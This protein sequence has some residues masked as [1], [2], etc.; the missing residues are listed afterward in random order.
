ML[1]YFIVIISLY[2]C[3]EENA[4]GKGKRKAKGKKKEMKENEKKE[5]QD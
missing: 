3:D 4:Q 5:T 1:F 2:I